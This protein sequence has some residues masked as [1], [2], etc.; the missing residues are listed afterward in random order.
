M[1]FDRVFLSCDLPN[2]KYQAKI[3]ANFQDFLLELNILGVSMF[4]N[5][6]TIS[7]FSI[8]LGIFSTTYGVSY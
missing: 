4:M 1:L 6:P 2:N 3:V 8:F 5:L 7:E